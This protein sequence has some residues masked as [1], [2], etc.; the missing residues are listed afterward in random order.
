MANYKLPRLDGIQ[1]F[2]L[3]QFTSQPQRLS[4]ELLKVEQLLFRGIPLKAI[5]HIRNRCPI[6]Y[7]NLIL[8]RGT[9][10][11]IDKAV[12]SCNWT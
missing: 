2:W 11:L 4:E 12:I 6:A 5:N 10:L 7:L 1:S 8:N 9:Q 3:K